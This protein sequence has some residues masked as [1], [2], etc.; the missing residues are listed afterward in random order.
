MILKTTLNKIREK[1]P[2]EP[3]WVKLLKHLNKTRADD[4]ELTFKTIL[5][6]NGIEDAVW[7]LRCCS[8]DHDKE[9]RL[10]A[11]WCARQVEHLGESS[12]IFKNTNDVSERYAHGKATIEE[13]IAAKAA[14]WSAAR[15]DA[16]ATEGA[17]AWVTA[18]RSAAWATTWFDAG[19][20]AWAAAGAAAWGT[21]NAAAQE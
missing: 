15:S 8:G 20:A 21:E 1:D 13:L 3:G 18:K 14:A 12:D 16:W 6:S 9:I 2:C 19:H 17:A 11:V 4:E 5:E 7:C 10:Y